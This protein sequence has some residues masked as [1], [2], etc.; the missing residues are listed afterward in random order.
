LEI[1]RLSPDN[2]RFEQVWDQFVRSSPSG[3]VFHLSTWRRVVEKAFRVTPHYLMATKGEEVR[4]VLPLFEIRGVLSGHV[5][6]S[7][8]Y[9][10]YGGLCATDSAARLV[11]LDE[12]RQLA[13]RQRVRYIELRHRY[14]PEPALPTKSR[15][16][17]FAKPLDPNPEVNYEAIPRK[18]RRMIRQGMKHGLESRHGWEHLNGFY[19]V[20]VINKQ[21][22]G[23]PPFPRRLFE[24]IRD[25]FGR[26]AQLLTIWHEGR[27]VAG[28][29][30]LFYEN[31]VMP[32]YGAALPEAFDLA[33]NDFMYW[34]LMREACL[35]GYQV[36]DFGRSREGTGA[37]HFKRHWG[38]EPQPLAYQ[39][40]LINGHS[41]PDL[42]PSNPR[43]RLF[44]EAWKRLP[45][46]VA[47]WVGPALTRWL[48]VD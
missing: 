18:Q 3:T 29:I 48:P 31:R 2:P 12:A 13:V 43:L 47:R 1:Q 33:V 22:L 4:G 23:S 17:V 5:F 40:V 25:H 36:F 11:L 34:E 30:S 15:Y 38:F 16:S 20:F 44:I 14:D 26:Q 35:A 7:V 28:V 19:K 8:L 42:S 6:V 45:L 27:M 24:A 9:G 39:Y 10:V 21:R 37:F 41:I 32:Y 46:P